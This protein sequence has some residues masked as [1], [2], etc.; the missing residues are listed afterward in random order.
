MARFGSP[1][2][3]DPVALIGTIR[4][5]AHVKWEDLPKQNLES[6]Q[7]VRPPGLDG[8]HGVA[9]F[10]FDHRIG[11]APG[12]P[13]ALASDAPFRGFKDGVLSPVISEP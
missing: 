2:T 6:I 10:G 4:V 1:E 9:L 11:M 13:V 3:A 12:A 7:A 8:R 5:Q